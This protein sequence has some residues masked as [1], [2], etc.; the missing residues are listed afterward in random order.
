MDKETGQSKNT[1][2]MNPQKI[3]KRVNAT[4]AVYTAH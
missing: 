1:V 4:F 3:Q 2:W